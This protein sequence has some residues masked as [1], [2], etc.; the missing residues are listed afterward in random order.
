MLDLNSRY[1]STSYEPM[2]GKAIAL[3]PDWQPDLVVGGGDMVAGQNP[4]LT[5]EVSRC[6]QL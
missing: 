1:G 4:S 5:R 2:I 3:I 6:G